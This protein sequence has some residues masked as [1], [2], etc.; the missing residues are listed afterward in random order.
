[1]SEY[2]RLG[3]VVTKADIELVLAA[4]HGLETLINR[5]TALDEKWRKR[6]TQFRRKGSPHAAAV[7]EDCVR[8]LRKAFLEFEP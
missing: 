4:H 3:H 1:V 5:I 8:D 2:D 7:T 6:A